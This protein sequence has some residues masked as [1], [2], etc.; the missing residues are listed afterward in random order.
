M[1]SGYYNRD[2]STTYV[3]EAEQKDMIALIRE[4]VE[5]ESPSDSP[6]AI[7]RFTDLFASKVF[8]IADCKRIPGGHLQCTF[9]LSGKKK[10]GQIMALGHS[11]TV[12]P[13]GTLARCRSGGVRADCGARVS[14][15]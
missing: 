14:W 12:Y 4:L 3:R 6:E 7:R 1:A 2:G 9:R 5:C 8:D 11:D 10:T 13:M 15:I